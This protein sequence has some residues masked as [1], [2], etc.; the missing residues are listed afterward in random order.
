MNFDSPLEP[1]KLIRRYKR[2]LADVELPTG[3]VITIHCPNTGSMKNCQE[4]GSRIWFSTS[5]NK[6]RKYPQTWQF[7]EV[8]GKHKVGI[9]TGLSNKL[10]V[11]AIENNIITQLQ[12]YE[13]LRTEVPYGEQK[14]RIDILLSDENKQSCYIEIKNVSLG[15]PGGLGLFPDAVTTRG[16]KHLEELMLMT[17]KGARGVLVF[18]VQHTGIQRVSPAD[19]IDPKYGSLLRE[20]LEN[21]VEAY[22]YRAKIEPHR[23]RVLLDAEI[24]VVV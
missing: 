2:F 19:K 10:V 20:A 13:T 18:C 8:N 14:S 24:P 9:N 16:Q 17:S 7:I 11:E 21:G 15:E 12:G 23:H 3:E 22:A 6:K 5:E 1:G 4:P